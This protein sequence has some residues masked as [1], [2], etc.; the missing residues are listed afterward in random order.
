MPYA[1]F[2]AKQPKPGFAKNNGRRGIRRHTKPHRNT[3]EGNSVLTPLQL[4][5]KHF[6]LP[7]FPPGQFA[8]KSD[9]AGHGAQIRTGA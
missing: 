3:V 2:F 4:L 6:F 9:R 5:F 1:C 7:P 8:V